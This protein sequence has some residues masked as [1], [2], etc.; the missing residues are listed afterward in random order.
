L[1]FLRNDKLG[2]NWN[3]KFIPETYFLAQAL[4]YLL[5]RFTSQKDIASILYAEYFTNKAI[6]TDLYYIF[7]IFAE[8]PIQLLNYK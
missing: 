7:C 2:D 6:I 8:L 5:F 1:S 3:L 4:L